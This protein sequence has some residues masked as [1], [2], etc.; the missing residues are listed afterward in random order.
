MK[1]LKWILYIVIALVVI[2]AILTFI[3]P[4]DMHTERSMVM[5]APKEVIWKNVVMFANQQKWSPWME[6]DPN[7]KTSIE[8]TDGTVGAVSK[9]DG[10][11]DVG[12][13]EQTFT[14]IEAMKSVESDL[15]FIKPWESHADAYIT[16][17]DT[18]GGVKVTWGFRGKMSRPWNVMGLFMN[19][20][21]AIGGDFEKGLAKLSALCEK[22]A[23]SGTTGG[24]MEIK[25]ITM[26]LKTYVGIRKVVAMKDI[27]NF[28]MENMPKTFSEIKK[29]GIQPMFPVSGLYYSWDEKKMMTDVA[30]AIP[31]ADANVN[32][33]GR[34]LKAFPIKGGKALTLDYYG[35]YEKIKAAHDKIGDYMKQ[36]NYKWVPPVIEEYITDPGMEKDSTKWLTKV[37]YF[38]E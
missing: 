5:K 25:E 1:V 12:K 29:A 28:F 34:V 11:D 37:I 38:Y 15:H 24:A 16:L 23:T 10:N 17:T 35:P 2:I 14:K 32:P 30:T 13:G 19:M 33:K 18:A 22:E 9:W 7:I 26:E 6:K 4:T 27:H 21:K 36:K 8:G 3:A 20:D 31:V